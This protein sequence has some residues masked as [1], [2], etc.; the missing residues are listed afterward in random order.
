MKGVRRT[1]K[2]S[3][4]HGGF[5]DLMT[6]PPNAAATAG[7][8]TGVTRNSTPLSP[9]RKPQDQSQISQTSRGSTPSSSGALLSPRQ[10]LRPSSPPPPPPPPPPPQDDW[11]SLLSVQPKRRISPQKSRVSRSPSLSFSSYPLRRSVSQA[12]S[13]NSEIIGSSRSN[14]YDSP[15]ARSH[16]KL[17]VTTPSDP[18]TV[19]TVVVTVPTE[20]SSNSS[21]LLMPPKVS[22]TASVLTDT[23]ELSIYEPATHAD[24]AGFSGWP[25]SD[26]LCES[27]PQNHPQDDKYAASVDSPVGS[28]SETI[29]E[30]QSSFNEVG[31][32]PASERTMGPLPSDE[33]EEKP[34]GEQ[35]LELS[36]PDGVEGKLIS[37]HTFES[38]RLNETEANPTSEQTI[39][40]S[41]SE[42]TEDTPIGGQ[43]LELSHPDGIE[44]KSTSEQSTEPSHPDE[45]VN[46][47][48]GEQTMGPPPSNESKDKST[49]ERTTEPPHPDETEDKPTGEQTIELSPSNEMKDKY[50]GEQE[51]ELTYPDET[52]EKP[53]NKRAIEPLHRDETED[54]SNSEHGTEPP[55]SN[56]TRNRCFGEQIIEPLPSNEMEDKSTGE[57][58]MEQ[59]PSGKAKDIPAGKQTM[60]LPYSEET[61]DKPTSEQT[62]ESSPS[63]ETEDKITNEQIVEDKHSNEQTVEHK[64]TTEQTVEDIRTNEQ[65]VEDKPYSEQT[66]EPLHHDE[67]E[68][69][70]TREQTMEA[71]NFD[72]TE[73]TEDKLAGEH[74]M[75]LSYSEESEYPPTSEQTVEPPR[76][77]GAEDKPAG[78]LNTELSSSNGMEGKLTSVQTVNPSLDHDRSSPLQGDSTK[79][80]NISGD[81]QELPSESADA[82]LVLSPLGTVPA[83]AT[84]LANR[85]DGSN[86]PPS[87]PSFLS[88]WDGADGW[89]DDPADD[90]VPDDDTERDDS[91]WDKWDALPSALAEMNPTKSTTNEPQTSSIMTVIDQARGENMSSKQQLEPSKFIE[92]RP[93]SMLSLGPRSTTTVKV[94]PGAGGPQTITSLESR[95]SGFNDQLQAPHFASPPP[96]VRKPLVSFPPHRVP[97][98]SESPIEGPHHRPEP[99]VERPSEVV[100]ESQ[101]LSAIEPPAAPSNEISVGHHIGPFDEPS[102]F[103]KLQQ[104][105][106]DHLEGARKEN[107][108]EGSIKPVCEPLDP[109]SEPAMGPVD[110]S[111]VDPAQVAITGPLNEGSLQHSARA[112]NALINEEIVAT[113]CKSVGHSGVYDEDSANVECAHPW[114]EGFTNWVDEGD[115]YVADDVGLRPVDNMHMESVD[116]GFAGP[117]ARNVELKDRSIVAF[118]DEFVVDPVN[119][120]TSGVVDEP[121]K[122]SN[123]VPTG[124]P[125]LEAA[126]KMAMGQ[127]INPSSELKDGSLVVSV[128]EASAVVGNDPCIDTAN[129]P[130]S[131]FFDDPSERSPIRPNLKSTANVHGESV[132]GPSVLPATEAVAVSVAE[133]VVNAFPDPPT[134]YS[135]GPEVDLKI[136]PYFGHP[137]HISAVP[138]LKPSIEQGVGFD[139]EEVLER[140]EPCSTEGD[141]PEA[142]MSHAD[143]SSTQCVIETSSET[144]HPVGSV[145]DA[146]TN[147]SSQ[148]NASLMAAGSASLLG[149]NVSPGSA[150]D[151]QTLP[152]SGDKIGVERF[153]PAPFRDP[154]VKTFIDPIVSSDSDRKEQ[155]VESKVQHLKNALSG[156]AKEPLTKSSEY[157]EEVKLFNPG[158]ESSAVAQAFEIWSPTETAKAS[159]K[160]PSS[161]AFSSAASAQRS[162]ASGSMW[163]TNPF[164]PILGSKWEYGSSNQEDLAPLEVISSTV[165]ANQLPENDRK[166]YDGS[167][168]DIISQSATTV[169]LSGCEKSGMEL[170]AISTFGAQ[171]SLETTSSEVPDMRHEGQKFS[172]CESHDVPLQ[173]RPSYQQDIRASGPP[174]HEP[175]ESMGW[176]SRDALGDSA[177]DDWHWD[178]SNK[179]ASDTTLLSNAATEAVLK[180]PATPVTH[181]QP[182]K[183]FKGSTGLTDA[184]KSTIHSEHGH[185]FATGSSVGDASIFPTNVGTAA[186]VGWDWVESPPPRTDT[187]G[188]FDKVGVS[189]N[190]V[191]EQ[192]PPPSTISQHE[193]SK[194]SF[195]GSEGLVGHAQVQSN[196]LMFTGSPQNRHQDHVM[197]RSVSSCLQQQPD[198]RRNISS[199]E[200]GICTRADGEA[201][202]WYYSEQTLPLD[203][204]TSIYSGHLKVSD[205]LGVTAE[206]VRTDLKKEESFVREPISC[207]SISQP[208]RSH[209]SEVVGQ[210]ISEN[211]ADEEF[212][213]GAKDL[214]TE[215][216][217][218][219]L[220]EHNTNTQNN[221]TAGEHFASNFSQTLQP[222]NQ[223]TDKSVSAAF[224]EDHS[225]N[226][227]REEGWKGFD[228]DFQGDIQDTWDWGI[229]SAKSETT[230][231]V[232]Q[233]FGDDDRLLNDNVPRTLPTSAGDKNVTGNRAQPLDIDNLQVTD[234]SI[235]SKQPSNQIE[236]H[237]LAQKRSHETSTS[238]NDT[239]DTSA[240]PSQV[241]QDAFGAAI[242]NPNFDASVEQEWN[243]GDGMYPT[244]AQGTF[245]GFGPVSESYGPS[246]P[247]VRMHQAQGSCVTSG[248]L[249]TTEDIR[250]ANFPLAEGSGVG[251][252]STS[253][254][255]R[256]LDGRPGSQTFVD[257]QSE[258]LEESRNPDSGNPGA[259]YDLAPSHHRTEEADPP[260]ATSLGQSSMD[261]SSMDQMFVGTSSNKGV[262]AED[263]I[264]S[265]SDPPP[266][267]LGGPSC[268]TLEPS[269]STLSAP[270]NDTYGSELPISSAI[271][272]QFVPRAVKP[273]PTGRATGPPLVLSGQPLAMPR[274]SDL[275]SMSLANEA[276]Y[277]PSAVRP[278][279]VPTESKPLDET[280]PVPITHEPLPILTTNAPLPIPATNEPLPVL[281]TNATFPVPVTN[282]SFPVPVSNAPLPVPVTN[283]PFPVSVTNEPLPIPVTNEPLPV[284]TTNAPLPV[285][286]TNEPFPVPVVNTPLSVP[287]TNEPLSAPV[288][289]EPVSVSGIGDA[290]LV[291]VTNASLSVPFRNAPPPA[292][293][294]NEPLPVPV[295]SEPK[296]IPVTDEPIPISVTS[297]PVPILFSNKPP[298]VTHVSNP[299]P[300]SFANNLPSV[301]FGNDSPPV[302]YPNEP[303]SVPFVNEKPTSKEL[304]SGLGK[305]EGW[306]D[307]NG[308]ESLRISQTKAMPYNLP[309]RSEQQNISSRKTGSPAFTSYPQTPSVN[310]LPSFEHTTVSSLTVPPPPSTEP[311]SQTNNL[312]SAPSQKFD[313]R[314][315]HQR[316]HAFES[317]FASRLDTLYTDSQNIQ[318]QQTFPFQDMDDAPKFAAVHS[319]PLNSQVSEPRATDVKSESEAPVSVGTAAPE[320]S[321]FHPIPSY[322]SPPITSSLNQN[323]NQTIQGLTGT[324]G[325]Q[326]NS[327]LTSAAYVS[328]AYSSRPIPTAPPI[329]SVPYG[330][331][332]VDFSP[333][334]P[335][336][337][338]SSG[339]QYPFSIMDPGVTND[340]EHHHNCPIISWGFGGTLV[341]SIPP[342]FDNDTGI[343]GS[344]NQGLETRHRV[345]LYELCPLASEIQDD[346]LVAS[347]EAIHPVRLPVSNHDLNLLADMCDRLSL[348]PSGLPRHAAEGR[349]AIWR[350]LAHMCRQKDADWRDSASSVLSGPSS[351]RMFGRKESGFLSASAEQS[352]FLD[353]SRLAPEMGSEMN[354]A[355][356]E[357]DRLVGEGNGMDALQIARDSGLWTIALVLG[358]YLDRTIQ[359][360]IISDF[361]RATLRD[362]SMLHTLCLT[363]AE[364]YSE[365]ELKATSA[366]GLNQW[367]RTIGILLTSWKSSSAS[368]DGNAARFL[369]IIEKVG[370]ELLS[371][372]CDPVAAHLCFLFSGSLSALSPE[373]F[374][375][376]GADHCVPAGRPRSLGSVGAVLQS[377]VFEAICCAQGHDMFYHLLPFRYLLAS[378]ICTVGR[379]DVALAHCEWIVSTL[380]G[381]F[382]SGRSELAS[383]FTLPFLASLEALDLRLRKNLGTD[384]QK[385]RVGTFAALRNSL[386]SVFNRK[387][388]DK[389]PV[390]DS[391][392]GGSERAKGF[393]ADKSMS[394]SSPELHSPYHQESRIRPDYRRPNQTTVK[395]P[396]LSMPPPSSGPHAH[397]RFQP[398]ADR[399]MRIHKQQNFDEMNNAKKRVLT[400]TNAGQG[401][402]R[403]VVEA[404]VSAADGWSSLMLKTVGILAPAGGDLS[405][406]PR[407]RSDD[408]IPGMAQSLLDGQTSGHST[409]DNVGPKTLTMRASSSTGDMLASGNSSPE[410]VGRRDH[411]MQDLG[412]SKEHWN[413]KRDDHGRIREFGEAST[414]T[415]VSKASDRKPPLPPKSLS[416]TEVGNGDNNAPRGWRARIAERLKS[417]FG[418]SK[419][420]HMGE[421]NKFVYD[422]KLGWVV[423]GEEITQDS[424]PPPPPPDDNE[425][426]G[427]GTTVLSSSVSYDDV[428]ENSQGGGNISYTDMHRSH[429]FQEDAGYNGLVSA[430]VPGPDLTNSNAFMHGAAATTDGL[431]FE[432]IHPRAPSNFT[433]FSTGKQAA[434]V[435]AS[436]MNRDDST[437]YT[438]DSMGTGRSPAQCTHEASMS[439]PQAQ[440]RHSEM[441]SQGSGVETSSKSL[442]PGS[443][444]AVPLHSNKYRAGTSRLSGKRAYVDT[445]NKGSKARTHGVMPPVPGANRLVIPTP[446]PSMGLT[447]HVGDGAGKDGGYHIFTPNP[448]ND[449]ESEVPGESDFHGQSVQNSESEFS[450]RGV[451]QDTSDPSESS[452]QSSI[453]AN[454][455]PASAATERGQ[456]GQNNWWPQGRSVTFS[457]P[458]NHSNRQQ[459]DTRAGTSSQNTGPRYPRMMA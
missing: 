299:P 222:G 366:A 403:Q 250:G 199:E 458:T 108:H 8:I 157:V 180:R 91:D 138:T 177:E 446:A 283:A 259:A 214:N 329:F 342:S 454:Y 304:P 379:P 96:S 208:H 89:G 298:V 81:V 450:D 365:L 297:E 219:N 396:F 227:L 17:T 445:F 422:E 363:V 387:P 279:S 392:L 67:T 167:S 143:D 98:N 402:P 459:P 34:A 335:P 103:D 209:R 201:S 92:E 440:M 269:P 451:I 52:E 386:S 230:T 282:E 105:S 188:D 323:G 398:Q 249:P 309:N 10:S 24:D 183:K 53:F 456:N 312:A 325:F 287:V 179:E 427:Q 371:S 62:V 306:S 156:R 41:P 388:A 30:P 444:T 246:K 349:A 310:V 295:K 191:E 87:L 289:N 385:S 243:W 382:Q 262:S 119:E 255:S 345:K 4:P 256:N 56:E 125:P 113:V 322:P 316:T 236:F 296:S 100:S 45:T 455:N 405:P 265:E 185:D 438:V 133:S 172:E 94:V 248:G 112:V 261:Q 348:A 99:T 225:E 435:R 362:S 193:A 16:S 218:S 352:L 19:P 65:T 397:H 453:N 71:P 447:R 252:D 13:S 367:R 176:A 239:P 389:G 231:T 384:D 425:L 245:V 411:G 114:D 347:C 235:A 290:P 416:G 377:L 207:S 165:D 88:G 58:T 240:H 3:R 137:A 158:L 166:N 211:P 36:H 151:A 49:S 374:V 420:A 205:P 232:N 220:L 130:C 153:F 46:E 15:Q 357:I 33:S 394:K 68:A 432:R 215:P 418:S 150:P 140:A 408:H 84:T 340:I 423:P 302:P 284:L 210:H 203:S 35:I 267:H 6:P 317:T 51:A 433:N 123:T 437:S 169:Q 300:V 121:A 307:P 5:A 391:N 118:T 85:L 253:G 145:F 144:L 26:D 122:E 268:G 339:F 131:E 373:K 404:N 77:N 189:N 229:S 198:S 360:D 337:P 305:T 242:D 22:S 32:K 75:K 417:A 321:P 270:Q 330:E 278:P 57:Q 194:I 221:G 393:D 38:S 168:T 202:K 275:F 361:A 197:E 355:A 370:Q 251:Q 344:V 21:Q 182:G 12:S 327:E 257:L 154:V 286:V 196:S 415:A 184:A 106:F 395:P 412:R 281:T 258:R 419:Q 83:P 116:E 60:E 175:P 43:N 139:E 260:L 414:S 436:R 39:K 277:T 155:N 132:T 110:K 29:I 264:L 308:R 127:S 318:A 457:E 428:L 383:V 181:P 187:S 163:A 410:R 320:G 293:V 324:V 430:P 93:S 142:F 424:A 134:D 354:E 346:G 147:P 234:N 73:E 14:L 76:S 170:N 7:V 443:S 291:P 332:K 80:P 274:A 353:S 90:S 263:Q 28:P 171:H 237:D 59:S 102:V 336:A 334:V 439:V 141:N 23:P 192:A 97:K 216:P 82:S 74:I 376:L 120:S 409:F 174:T 42:E 319:Q 338:L 72:E 328:S 356:L 107:F 195:A 217:V 50:A 161:T 160:T 228:V 285:P 341:V 273:L 343:R 159:S 69:T 101:E 117:A 448:Q 292:L 313:Q 129:E 426:A 399:P 350:L 378:E 146:Y 148:A 238:V 400:S 109:A 31:H 162:E 44:D 434:D 244:G 364:N 375:L 66:I 351:V 303:L 104:S 358:T 164:R 54:R 314:V 206:R 40:P 111:C 70:P 212:L 233:G 406:P 311:T 254:V 241:L 271:E 449:Y 224:G 47:P 381:V 401:N 272:S 294:T 95:P 223:D 86:P 27:D 359:N 315:G 431:G 266:Q 326:E 55:P 37:E 421:K 390:K 1:K 173:T 200:S 136:D 442:R 61:E 186:A 368:R 204:D 79:D 9:E 247:N 64:R 288:T 63:E 213:S 25:N 11:E 78:E 331:P 178:L 48:A 301:P 441:S 226:C 135:R 124:E 149:T 452:I 152:D 429:S 115:K 280:P 190:G 276:P 372:K 369:T 407:A 126:S 18:G 2:V 20:V 413:S 333:G 128:G 380:K